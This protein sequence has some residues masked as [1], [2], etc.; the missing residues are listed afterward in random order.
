MK[1]VRSCDI[2]FSVLPLGV[3]L[4][5]NT[6]VDRVSFIMGKTNTDQHLFLS[7]CIMT[8]SKNL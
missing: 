3:Y 8:V 7:L 5:L 2:S 6:V 4:M 1:N